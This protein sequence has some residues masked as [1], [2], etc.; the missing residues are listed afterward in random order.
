M[1][2][3][4]TCAMGSEEYTH[5]SPLHGAVANHYIPLQGAVAGLL[6]EL[7]CEYNDRRKKVIPNKVQAKYPLKLNF[8]LN[9]VGLEMFSRQ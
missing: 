4:C 8:E 9:E 6:I 7:N 2:G 3:G 1:A 5:V